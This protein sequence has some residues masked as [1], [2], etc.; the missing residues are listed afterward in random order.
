MNQQFR[1]CLKNANNIKEEE[2][3]L[4]DKKVLKVKYKR[5]NCKKKIKMLHRQLQYN[6]EMILQD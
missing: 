3:D 1:K 6:G 5:E 4:M 2:R